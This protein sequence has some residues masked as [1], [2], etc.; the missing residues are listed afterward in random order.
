VSTPVDIEAL[1]HA[2]ARGDRP[3]RVTTHAQVEAFKDGLALTDL[4]HVFEEG[5]IIEEYDGDR[6]LLFG[7]AVSAHLPVHVVIEAGPDEVVIV[8]AY[9]PD[10]ALWIGYTERRR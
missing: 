10:D 7:W 9:V 6:A 8:T 1:R 2:V 4:R 3:L 5:R